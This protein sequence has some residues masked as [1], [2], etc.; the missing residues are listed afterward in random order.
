MSNEGVFFESVVEA[1][2]PIKAWHPLATKGFLKELN[3]IDPTS[4]HT[5]TSTFVTTKS[6]VTVRNG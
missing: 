1:Q 4:T 6:S 3:N 5:P 2:V